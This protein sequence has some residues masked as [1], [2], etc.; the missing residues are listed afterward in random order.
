M[1]VLVDVASVIGG[2]SSG[3]VELFEGDDDGDATTVVGIGTLL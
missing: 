2:E 3:L 1:G